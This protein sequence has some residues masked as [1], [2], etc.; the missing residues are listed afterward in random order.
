MAEGEVARQKRGQ[1]L[2]VGLLLLLFAGLAIYGWQLYRTSEKQQEQS[3]ALPGFNTLLINTQGAV[4]AV[5]LKG[6]DDKAVQ[7]L[8]DLKL[9]ALQMVDL[10]DC[11]LR[12]PGFEAIL[13]YDQLYALGLTGSQFDA[14][15]LFRLSVLSELRKLDLTGCDVPEETRLKLQKV[16][17]HTRLYH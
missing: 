8:A 11:R 7:Q 13:T 1:R 14:E 5:G 4:Q 15:L 2:Y 12:E 16:L 10:I 9:P 17:P 6:V 3:R